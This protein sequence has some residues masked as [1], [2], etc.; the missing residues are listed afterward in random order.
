MTHMDNPVYRGPQ[1]KFI[2][3]VLQD[4]NRIPFHVSIDPF[5][6]ESNLYADL[7]LPEAT[8]LERWDLLSPPPMERV[9]F[10][11]LRQPVSRPMGQSLPFSDILMELAYRV[12]GG[13]ER[14]FKFGKM[15]HYIEAMVRKVPRLVDAGGMD[16][17]MEK[18]IWVDPGFKARGG[19]Q[20]KNRI[21][22]P[23]G[24]FEFEPLPAYAPIPHHQ[25][26]RE[27]E[28]HL[29]T[30]QWNVHSYSQTANCKWLMEIV[31]R[32][33]LWIHE[34]TARRLHVEKG[35]RV[36]ITSST[37][38][39]VT[40]VFVTQGIHP[41]TVALSDNVG[42]WQYGHVAEG[43]PFR[44]EDS[45][46]KLI[47]WG[48]HGTGVHPSSIIPIQLDPVG[49]GQGWMDTVIRIEKV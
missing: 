9:P 23:S 48:K 35:D 12:G 27:G 8:Y 37:G 13:M 15:E 31:H 10:I 38:S 2:S 26:L 45:E 47:W 49:E 5:L 18:G 3:Q 7:L 40:P 17:L 1:S 14:Y 41:R 46:T 6:N 43:K 4:E 28:F 22:T 19:L 34:E 25:Q 21:K 36:R 24:K 29:I 33:P 44:S 30:F 20:D 39:L 32:N 42:R 11:A 16:Y